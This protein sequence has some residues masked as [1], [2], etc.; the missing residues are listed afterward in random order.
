MVPSSPW[1]TSTG[2][3]NW[4]AAKQLNDRNNSGRKNRK[5]RTRRRIT[6][7]ARRRPR[8]LIGPAMNRTRATLDAGNRAFRNGAEETNGKKVLPAKS[9][10]RPAFR[11]PKTELEQAIQRYI[12]LFD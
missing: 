5:R 12:D 8:E 10:R 2:G 4:M 6:T 7:S 1:S 9:M 11:Q 3:E